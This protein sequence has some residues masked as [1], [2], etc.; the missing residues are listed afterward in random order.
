MLEAAVLLEAG[1]NAFVNEVWSTYVPAEESV[2]RCVARDGKSEEAVRNII[3]AQV[4]LK[5]RVES[6]NVV[7][8]TVWEPT[9]TQRYCEKAWGLLLNRLQ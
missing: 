6:S 8:S 1:W 7:I 2:A 9:V 4:N 3:A 5:E